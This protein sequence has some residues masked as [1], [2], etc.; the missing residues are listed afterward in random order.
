MHSNDTRFPSATGRAQ[1]HAKQYLQNYEIVG[2]LSSETAFHLIFMKI[3][4][5]F[6]F[7]CI[8]NA[9][10]IQTL[11]G[12]TALRLYLGLIG[13]VHGGIIS[14]PLCVA[15]GL[16]VKQPQSISI[17]HC[18]DGPDMGASALCHRFTYPLCHRL[19][20]A[21]NRPEAKLL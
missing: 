15:L 7:Q 10:L 20:N 17:R 9:I 8:E 21:P 11:S 6:W 14:Q 12:E 3:N 16:L 19:T 18:L 5:A 13:I 4:A 2:I 1:A